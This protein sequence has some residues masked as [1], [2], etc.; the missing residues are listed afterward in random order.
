MSPSE[1]S[2]SIRA[3]VVLAC[4]LF[5]AA[6]AVRGVPAERVRLPE[7]APVEKPRIAEPMQLLARG[8]SLRAAELDRLVRPELQ[9]TFAASR[10]LVFAL[11]DCPLLVEWLQSAEGQR[12]ERLLTD[13]RNGS[14]EEALAALTL[15]FQ[16][17]RATDWKPGLTAHAEHAE[18]LGGLLQDWLRVWGER[19]AKDPLLVEP[20]LGATLL[21]ARAMRAAW[22][23]PVVGYNEAPYARARDFLMQSTGLA[24]PKRTALGEALQAR[25]ARAAVR[26][27]SDKDVLLGLEEECAALFPDLEGECAE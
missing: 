7:D 13:L 10:G 2:R 4:L 23:A 24:T 16:L 11:R 20:A 1:H 5:A 18:R 8:A 9:P 12:T 17:A 22:R 27:A 19:S 21:Y 26:L 15:V 6:L 14:P 3:V 25:F